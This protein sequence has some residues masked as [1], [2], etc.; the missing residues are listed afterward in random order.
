VRVD[1]LATLAFGCPIRLQQRQQAKP[2]CVR[3]SHRQQPFSRPSLTPQ[4]ARSGKSHRAGVASVRARQRRSGRPI[5]RAATHRRGRQGDGVCGGA[6]GCQEAW[7]AA[8]AC[9]GRGGGHLDGGSHGLA[10]HG[11]PHHLQVA[12]PRPGAAQLRGADRLEQRGTAARRRHLRAGEPASAPAVGSHLQQHLR[13]APR[14]CSG[15]RLQ[16]C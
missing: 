2:K 16:A 10:G 5:G 15:S 7:A 13:A 11:P 8:D 9:A 6:A 14:C 3:R 12:Q 4:R 1:V